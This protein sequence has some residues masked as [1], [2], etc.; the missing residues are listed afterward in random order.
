M[1]VLGIDGPAPKRPGMVIWQFSN[2]LERMAVL[3][4]LIP[5]PLRLKMVI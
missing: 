5:V 3:G 4:M 1:V 2:G